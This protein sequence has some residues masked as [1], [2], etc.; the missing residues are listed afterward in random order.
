M[1]PE[2]EE[3]LREVRELRER[4]SQ[5]LEQDLYLIDA[6]YD[7]QIRRVHAST[8]WNRSSCACFS[9]KPFSLRRFC[10]RR[11]KWIRRRWER[12]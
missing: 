7:R 8:L 11:V 12:H 9:S 1:S 10:L 3:I 2:A 6:T 4:R 5:S